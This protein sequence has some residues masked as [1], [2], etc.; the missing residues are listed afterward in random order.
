HPTAH[1]L[2]YTLSLHDAL[3]IYFLF[4]VAQII[5]EHRLVV[6]PQ[7]RQVVWDLHRGLRKVKWGPRQRHLAK[8]W[9]LQPLQSLARLELGMIRSEEHTSELQSHLNL[10]CRLL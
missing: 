3:P 6:L 7:Q 2:I 5:S 10:V 1:T 9:H 4:A 8:A